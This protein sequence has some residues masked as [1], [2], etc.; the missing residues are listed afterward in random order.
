MSDIP[1]KHWRESDGFHIDVSDLLPPEPMVAILELI[2]QPGMEGPVIV[3]HHREPLY[4][5][6][7]LLERNWDYKIISSTPGEICLLLTK[8]Q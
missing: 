1:G 4:L 8:S 6:P 7:E 3:H 5:Y 2:E